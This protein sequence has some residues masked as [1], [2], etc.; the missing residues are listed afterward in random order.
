[1][2]NN[3]VTVKQLKDYFYTH[4]SHISLDMSDEEIEDYL[5][6]DYIRKCKDV[7]Q[8]ANLLSD[9]ILSQGFGDVEE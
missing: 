3:T 9:Y 7:P 6:Q 5:R 2:T 1:M 8:I 4:Y